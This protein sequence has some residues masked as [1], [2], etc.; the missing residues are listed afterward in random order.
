MAASGVPGFTEDQLEEYL[1]SGDLDPI[2]ETSAGVDSFAEIYELNGRLILK[3]ASCE[4]TETGF[5]VLDTDSL[6]EARSLAE[7]QASELASDSNT[8][9]DPYLDLGS[10]AGFGSQPDR[11]YPLPEDLVSVC[12]Y[13][14]ISD[15]DN[16]ECAEIVMYSRSVV[17]VQSTDPEDAETVL[18]FSTDKGLVV[19]EFESLDEVKATVIEEPPGFTL[20]FRD[21]SDSEE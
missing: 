7:S 13:T 10:L 11:F 15:Y 1:G 2:F 19:G 16:G 21:L 14:L 5:R 17:A 18:A 8:N 20:E 9:F 4:W 6:D 3:W 12:S